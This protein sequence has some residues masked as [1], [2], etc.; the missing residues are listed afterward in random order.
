MIPAHFKSEYEIVDWLGGHENFEQGLQ[1]LRRAVAGN[2]IETGRAL[3]ERWLGVYDDVTAGRP[4]RPAPRGASAAE[5]E[6]VPAVA[7]PEVVPA[8]EAVEAIKPRESEPSR[9]ALAR[10]A[11][12]SRRAAFDPHLRTEPVME[13]LAAP[14][15]AP[16]PPVIV[17]RRTLSEAASK[18][19]L[20]AH[21]RAGAAERRAGR[22]VNWGRAAFL[23]ATV[24]LLAVTLLA[25][26]L[27]PQIGPQLVSQLRAL[28]RLVG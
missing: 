1:E 2:Q 23:V 27:W 26:A 22:A 11:A 16:P 13:P 20:R 15:L 6:A 24:A 5:A 12:N 28:A 21:E 17:E 4:V 10:V 3:V 7:A 8:P 18:A 25:L 14:A 9:P 19:L